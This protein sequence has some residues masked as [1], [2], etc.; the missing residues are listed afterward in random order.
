MG[1]LVA[2]T[3]ESATLN[4]ILVIIKLLALA[5]FIAFALP[6]FDLDNL[7]RFM[8]YG[9][10]SVE[11]GGET[12]GVMAAAAIVFFAF[13]DFDAVATSEEE[14]KNPKGDMTISISGCLRVCTPILK[15]VKSSW[16]ERVCK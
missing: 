1:M 13:Y 14:V 2:G 10:G 9:F 6:A 15:N 4:I 11:S 8:P 12:R 7:Q 3:R 5:A 16:R